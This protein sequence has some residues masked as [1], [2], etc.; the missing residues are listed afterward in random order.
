[1]AK[2]TKISWSDGTLNFWEGC[3]KQSP[4]CKNC[5]AE[6]RDQRFHEG[7]HW[8][9]DQPRKKSKS[10]LDS[11]RSFNTLAEKGA[12]IRC[13]G[14][15][16]RKW[17]GDECCG[18]NE[19]SAQRPI[20]FVMSLG[21]FGDPEVP[22]EWR[23]EALTAILKNSAMDYM[24]LTKHI[25]T[26]IET[27]QRAA[28][29]MTPSMRERLLNWMEGTD[30]PPNV[31]VGTSIESVPFAAP[32][33]QALA[34]F[35]AVRRFVSAEP[36]LQGGWAHLL[37]KHRDK[38]HLVIV[39]GESGAKARPMHWG[40]AAEIEITCDRLGIPYHFKQHGTWVDV[41]IVKP[42]PK[43]ELGGNFLHLLFIGPVMGYDPFNPPKSPDILVW[44]AG[45]H[46]GGHACDESGRTRTEMLTFP[47]GEWKHDWVMITGHG[48]ANRRFP[49]MAFAK[50]FLAANPCDVAKLR[51]LS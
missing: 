26:L 46:R 19:G 39:G 34:D 11:I 37:P 17:R 3:T 14:C 9:K 20:M 38:L 29:L 47:V 50:E 18:V 5:Y 43:L 44:R 24:I 23:A 12:F 51:V 15:G 45:K 28:L 1:M 21:D 2:I 40:W 10:A 31:A 4:G 25:E 35:P 49:G 16:I 42:D 6:E 7:A 27:F 33:L 32:R 13:M 41:R 36:L 30:M 48:K 8:G 22:D